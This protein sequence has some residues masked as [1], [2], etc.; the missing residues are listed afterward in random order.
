HRRDCPASD[1]ASTCSTSPSRPASA[2]RRALSCSAGIRAR[3]FLCAFITQESAL[4][5][6]R[7]QR[8]S[9]ERASVSSAASPSAERRPPAGDATRSVHD[10][11]TVTRP[12][13]ALSQ[14][15]TTWPPRRREN[16]TSTRC[17]RSGWNGCVMTT[18]A[19]RSL[20]D[21]ALCRFRGQ[22]ERSLLPVLFRDVNPLHRLEPV[23]LVAQRIDDAPGLRRRHAVGGLPVCPW[24]H[25]AVV[26]VDA[27]VGQLKQAEV[28]QLPVQLC[29]RQAA[30][31][32]VT[33]DIQHSF[34][35]LHYAYL[36]LFEYPSPGPLRPA[37]GV[38]V[39][40]GRSLLL[41]LLRGLC[42]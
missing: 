32:A 18:K 19:E 31:A 15:R 16:S 30:P 20:G 22:A 38:T 7:N 4:P 42:H 2:R 10:S 34:G 25:R 23:A 5:G 14:A 3:S 13:E 28:E 1:P 8:P 26:G 24:R 12:S 11:K 36:L 6:H 9:I 33:E 37:D 17:P 27:P 41:R 29:A 40:P 21:T 35:V 39:L